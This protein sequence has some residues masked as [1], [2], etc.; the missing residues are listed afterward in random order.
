MLDLIRDS[1]F[2][3]LVQ[4]ASRGRVFSPL[5]TRDPSRL[6]KYATSNSSSSSSIAI[7]ANASGGNKA[8]PEKGNDFQLV[9]WDENDP[10]VSHSYRI[11]VITWL[12]L[13]SFLEIG[14]PQRSSL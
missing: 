7:A 1:V 3:R 9:N 5:E 8:D 4:L 10:E 11:I 12:T 13:P 6:E 14:R 2:G